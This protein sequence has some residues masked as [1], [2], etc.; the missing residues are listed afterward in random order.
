MRTTLTIDDDVSGMLQK[1][2]RE[3]G[4]SF[5]A[6]VNEL[7]R[8]GLAA[9]GSASLQRDPVP[10]VTRP[11]RLRSGYD[12]DKLNQLVDELEV[13]EYRRKEL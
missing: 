12:P 2:A 4:V 7:L 11:L 6:I 8:A 5:K 10:V 1:K 3:Q 13:E 9:S